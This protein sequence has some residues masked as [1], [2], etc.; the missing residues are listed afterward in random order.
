MNCIHCNCDE[1][2]ACPGGCFWVF[3]NPPICSRC[4]FDQ[5]AAASIDFDENRRLMIAAKLMETTERI[6]P[7]AGARIMQAM[8]DLQD[9]PGIDGGFDP[10]NGL[11]DSD[12]IYSPPPLWMPGE[13]A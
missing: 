4:V 9:D 7:G 6:C 12:A 2:H 8:V 11:L 3:T 10:S 13:G 5:L 1:S